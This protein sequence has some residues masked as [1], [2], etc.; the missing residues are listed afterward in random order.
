MRSHSVVLS[1]PVCD[2]LL[3]DPIYAFLFDGACLKDLI[4][5]DIIDAP[6]LTLLSETSAE[7]SLDT[8]HDGVNLT[9]LSRDVN[10]ELHRFLPSPLDLSQLGIRLDLAELKRAR[11]EVFKRLLLPLGDEIDSADVLGFLFF[12][13]A[14]CCSRAKD[15]G[16]CE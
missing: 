4:H 3:E 6:I 9:K 5:P 12:K 7:L 2:L 10:L 11:E 14:A 8:I 16:I 15:P 13:R 1:I